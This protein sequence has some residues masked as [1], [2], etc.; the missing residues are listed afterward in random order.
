[1]K[2]F[3]VN[4][5]SVPAERDMRHI[6]EHINTTHP[7]IKLYIESLED[8][9]TGLYKHILSLEPDN[10]EIKDWVELDIERNTRTR[11]TGKGE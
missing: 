4:G 10:K 5:I 1:M 2:G 6:N 11:E 8:H 9:I 7:D 3:T